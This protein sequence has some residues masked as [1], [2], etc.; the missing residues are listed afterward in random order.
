MNILNDTKNNKNVLKARKIFIKLFMFTVTSL[1]GKVIHCVTMYLFEQ[2][3]T[4][5]RGNKVF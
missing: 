4:V 3:I 1:V 2:K 5:E